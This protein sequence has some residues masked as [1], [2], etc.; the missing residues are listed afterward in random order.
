MRKA[1]KMTQKKVATAIGVTASTITQYEQDLIAPKFQPTQLLCKLF[2]CS[3]DWLLKGIDA[4][5]GNEFTNLLGSSMTLSRRLPVLSYSQVLHWYETKDRSTFNDAFE[6]INVSTDYS[7]GAFAVIVSGGYMEGRSADK[8]IPRDS[9]VTVETNMQ[10]SKMNGKV[11][12]AIP[13]LSSDITIKELQI[14]ANRKYLVPWNERF[15]VD[16]INENCIIL[17]YVKDVIIRLHK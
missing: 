9:I 3:A 16:E 7:E 14:D 12:I 10:N 13:N 11:V 8:F 6:W 4:P 17:G 15:Q 5:S 1:M 2:N